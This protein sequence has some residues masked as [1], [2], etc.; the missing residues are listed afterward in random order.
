MSFQTLPSLGA[1]SPTPLQ[2][3]AVYAG[4]LDNVIFMVT[5]RV[6]NANLIV[7][8]FVFLI[9]WDALYKRLKM[10][11]L[12]RSL[13]HSLPHS[14]IHSLAYVHTHTHTHT[15]HNTDATQAPHKHKNSDKLLKRKMSMSKI[16]MQLHF[17]C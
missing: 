13:T 7:S 11:S 8:V 14:R 15:Q 12:T 3:R 4:L 5:K 17:W 2:E 9:L 10:Y 1:H 6:H 16:P